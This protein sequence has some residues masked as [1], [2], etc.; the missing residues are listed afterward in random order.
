M[1]LGWG[2]LLRIWFSWFGSQLWW[3]S[4]SSEATTKADLPSCIWHA[5]YSRMISVAQAKDKLPESRA[6]TNQN[7]LCILTRGR[8]FGLQC[9]IWCLLHVWWTNEVGSRNIHDRNG[10][11][12]VWRNSHSVTRLMNIINQ[13]KIIKCFCWG[14]NCFRYLCP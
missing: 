5:I 1:S 4:L 6:I 12:L 13:G 3:E 2:W 11:V 7:N 9:S 8:I 10:K 14:E